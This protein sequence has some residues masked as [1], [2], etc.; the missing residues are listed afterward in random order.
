MIKPGCFRVVLTALVAI[1]SGACSSDENVISTRQGYLT[2]NAEVDGKFAMADGSVYTLPAAQTPAAEDFAVTLS[3]SDSYSH[4]WPLL[5]QFPADESYMSGPYTVEMIHGPLKEGPG[6][7]GSDR[8]EIPAGG[9]S[10]VSV[11]C[12]PSTAMA[13]VEFGERGS[14]GDYELKSVSVHPSGAEYTSVSDNNIIFMAPGRQHYYA[15]IADRAGN[16]VN[17]A[18]P[19]EYE[20]DRACGVRCEFA[21]TEAG[22]VVTQY[23]DRASVAV[24]ADLFSGGEPE[25]TALGFSE[26]SVLS[27]IEGLTLSVPVKMA[28]SS[29]RALK[30]LRLSVVSPIL[31]TID[32]PSELDLLNLSE[33]DK[34]FLEI[35][36]FEFT[37]SADRR[38][39]EANFTHV[40]EAM[41]SYTNSVSRFILLAEDI[42]GVCSAPLTLTVDTRTISFQVKDIKPAVVGIDRASMRLVPSEDRIERADF[43]IFRISDGAVN[44][45]PCEITGWNE[46]DDGSVEVTFTVPEGLDPVDVAVDYMGLPRVKVT[47]PRANPDFKIMVDPFA[48]TALI[49]VA[50]EDSTVASAVTRLASFMVNG[51]R[52]S[53]WTRDEKSHVIVLNGLN[54]STEY[55]IGANLVAGD[56]N[57]FLKTV[58]EAAEAIPAG[59]FSDWSV[60]YDVKG[61]ACGG[62]YSSTSLSVV[63][64]QNFADV[65]V[66]WPK[67]VWSSINA[68]TFFEG[69]RNVNTWYMQP[70]A[71]I[72]QGHVAGDTKAICISSVGWDHDGPAIPDYVQKPGESLMY[73]NNV[74]AVANKSAGRLFIGEY[75]F[76]EK[77]GES[78]GFGIDFSSRPSA[79]NGFFM[80]LPDL[81]D[82]S[83]HGYVEVEVLNR[84]EGKETVIAYGYHEFPTSPDYRTFTV[85][86]EYENFGLKATGLRVMFCSSAR[87]G[88]PGDDESRVPVTAYPEFGYMKGSSLWIYNIS[89]SY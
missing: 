72:R 37:V 38:S 79:L 69:S 54:P 80:Y 50:A 39:V 53:V 3:Q 31:N 65:Y 42:T 87:A 84:T 60:L 73:N 81:T 9:R 74:P 77:D 1:A 10:S 44:P 56:K 40:L 17:V 30:A 58:T 76:S 48:T 20:I 7:S 46:L 61:M 82:N 45:T 70:S 35:S 22:L 28:V 6:F 59:D 75:S 83:D 86:L 2:L 8:F 24:T 85:P 16:T 52:A 12:T 88:K 41:A 63:N 55:T 27:V 47:I 43:E 78:Y 34:E 23:D 21:L 57:V 15:E 68:K 11:V 26:D 29:P 66:R 49:Y 25:I 5:S 71:E 19:F 36:D 18:V 4:S 62:R 64:R 33:Q 89:F 67:K 14:A 32:A 13:D 51:Q